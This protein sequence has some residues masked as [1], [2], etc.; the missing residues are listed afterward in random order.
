VDKNK[1]RLAMS[2]GCQKS[3]LQ[4]GNIRTGII[5]IQAE[6]PGRARKNTG[7]KRK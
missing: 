4:K 5:H 2:E 1:F 3:I 7:K 6:H